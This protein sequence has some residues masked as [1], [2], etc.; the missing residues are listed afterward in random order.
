MSGLGKRTGWLPLVP[1]DQGSTVRRQRNIGPGGVARAH[2]EGGRHARRIPGE[3]ENGAPQP[4]SAADVPPIEP[5]EPVEP[6]EPA[7]PAE[8][9][10]GRP[11]PL[12]GAVAERLPLPVRALVEGLPPG[13]QRGRF[14]LHPGPAAVVVLVIVLGLA[15]AALAVGW[16]RPRIV[17]AKP[18]PAATVLATGAPIAG[19]AP[20]HG[21]HG[22]GHDHDGESAGEPGVIVVHVAGKVAEPGIVELPAGSRVVDAIDAAGGADRGVDIGALNL[23]RILTDGEQIAV[24][25]EPAPDAAIDPADGDGGALVNINS[26]TAEQL[27]ILPGIGPALAARIIQWRDQNGRFTSVEELLEVSGI[28]PAKFESLAGLVTL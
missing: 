15:I 8:P 2:R 16:G 21:H 10:P 7:E 27:T 14:G 6:V 9:P 4:G 20:G 12:P 26:A 5:A 11:G 28:G 13:V 25:V 22:D 23:A 1:S 18:E 3:N 24:G 19:Q 17:T